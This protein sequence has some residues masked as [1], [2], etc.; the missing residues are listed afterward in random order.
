MIEAQS[1]LNVYRNEAMSTMLMSRRA[2]KDGQSKPGTSIY[3][4]LSAPMK[5][6]AMSEL[7]YMW[8]VA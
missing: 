4:Q 2:T 1:S 6:W 3:D 7:L 5:Q 8:M